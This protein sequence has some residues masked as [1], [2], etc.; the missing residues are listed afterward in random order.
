MPYT[1]M[2]GA[3]VYRVQNGIVQKRC[4][5]CG[6]WTPI[7]W[8]ETTGH[9]GKLVFRS[10]PRLGMK[11]ANGAIDTRNP[12]AFPKLK[13]V[14]LCPPCDDELRQV[15]QTTEPGRTPFLPVKDLDQYA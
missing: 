3:R 8:G 11:M 10:N 2:E 5:H 13:K 1:F 15:K 12:V 9:I 4:G 6:T 14:T 7:T